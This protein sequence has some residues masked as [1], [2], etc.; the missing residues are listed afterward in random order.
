MKISLPEQRKQKSR[1]WDY[2]EISHLTQAHYCLTLKIDI[3]RS[4]TT[5]RSHLNCTENLIMNEVP[6]C[7]T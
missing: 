1:F 7:I 5:A 2:K 4:H 6:T 3:L